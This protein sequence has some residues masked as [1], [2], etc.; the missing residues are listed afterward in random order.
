MKKH[1]LL[2]VSTLLLI[3]N[4]TLA[5]NTTWQQQPFRVQQK[6]MK[7]D[8][9]AVM[10][11]LNTL[12]IP[13][14]NR[15]SIGAIWYYN[16]ENKFYTQTTSGKYPLLFNISLSGGTGINYN[17]ATGVI[18]S[19]GIIS[20]PTL[21]QVTDVGNTT[22]NSVF[23]TDL[24]S[25]I[26]T[27][28]NGLLFRHGDGE[29]FIEEISK[30]SN[31]LNPLT[32]SGATIKL[33]GNAIFPSN[34]TPG[35][36]K[37]PTGVDALGNWNWG[38]GISGSLPITYNSGTGIISI[39]NAQAN[40]VNKGAATFRSD[41]FDDDGQGA[42][43]LDTVN[44]PAYT[45]TQA[46]AR[47]LQATIVPTVGDMATH[48]PATGDS[49]MFVTD[50]LR[51]GL[52][53]W[54]TSSITDNGTKFGNWWRLYDESAGLN[55]CW[56]GAKGDG[57]TDDTG[58]IQAAV[59]AAVV[60][61]KVYF[62]PRPFSSSKFY[63]TTGSVTV[64]TNG[65]KIYGDAEYRS[66][67]STIQATS[68]TFPLFI[69]RAAEVT[70]W[71]IALRGNG[72]FTILDPSG[73]G[74]WGEGA[75]IS[76]IR[77]EG[78]AGANGDL[79]VGHCDF[80]Y[81]DTAIT[82]KARN[83][84]ISSNNLFSQTKHPLVILAAN[85]GQQRGFKIQNNWVHSCGDTTVGRAFVKCTYQ[86]AFQI[87]ITNNQIDG[88][89]NCMLA[90]IAADSS[91]QIT[92]N[93]VSLGRG[94]LI[95]LT[96]VN[97]GVIS[98]NYFL[99]G[100][101]KTRGSG[102][103]LT[104]SL[105]VTITGNNIIQPAN[106]GIS[107]VNGDN[108]VVT[109]NYVKD[110]S[111]QAKE[112]AGN[113][114]GI[115]L[116]AS[117]NSN[118]VYTN[119]LYA[120]AGAT[121]DKMIDYDATS[122]TANHVALNDQYK[123]AAFESL[124]GL[125]LGS[126]PKAVG[127]LFG[128]YDELSKYDFTYDAVND[129]INF[130]RTGVNTP[131]RLL[132][133]GTARMDYLID[134]SLGTARLGVGNSNGYISLTSNPGGANGAFFQYNTAGTASPILQ[135]S[136]PSSAALQ[137]IV[138]AADTFAVS[139]P[140]NTAKATVNGNIVWH[141][142]N[143]GAGSGLDADLLDGLSSASFAKDDGTSTAYIRNTTTVQSANWHISGTAKITRS[144]PLLTFADG[145]N[146]DISIQMTSGR[147]DFSNTNATTSFTG[148]A[149]VVV[150]AGSANSK[151]EV[152]GSTGFSITT[153]AGNITAGAHRTIRVTGAAAVVTLP[154]A[155]SCTG[156]EY[157]IINYNTGG[158]ITI[159]S[160]LS[161]TNTATTTIANGTIVWVQSDGTNWYQIK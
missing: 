45:K 21:Q 113:F 108:C 124:R 79:K 135:F 63:K 132:S 125:E 35:L 109:G 133:D 89:P 140:G 114:D 8:S 138:A 56:F 157:C 48:S 25:N 94:G 91:V 53:Y 52:F 87:W 134:N 43:S 155:S 67:S 28:G 117:S 86:N 70:F 103:L 72:T 19:T 75:T 49:L 83:A 22:T 76:G 50:S 95:S 92:D 148:A 90:D 143:D 37:I 111:W 6:M 29:G 151:F 54:S 149:N 158:N 82:F 93:N 122:L 121:Y 39:A 126:Q 139:N 144:N 97:G 105:N 147:L 9:A 161:P 110:F 96:G 115:S 62:P 60:G 51:G 38:N 69:V 40:G 80:I 7:F 1:I 61:G 142:G 84:D 118:S 107:L 34:G 26:P 12:T 10:P 18:S 99:G 102:I 64:T 14:T 128:R 46:N 42:I 98:G 58:P 17:S 129:A 47:F 112:N 137:K 81:L 27:S 156:R 4:C 3:L 36:N 150:G 73:A 154:T 100:S 120:R 146:S 57:T 130:N 30:P 33:N 74:R 59:N 15:D 141:A 11:T 136:A 23:L 153:A 159:S 41:H 24:S 31:V 68:G 32:I 44:W 2:L 88:Q 131:M 119:Q 123:G 13:F 20:M 116:D 78:D 66:Y 55:V 106:T 16:P 160:F 101:Y 85:T 127:Y 65:V 77:V 5:Q 145:T 71:G 152:A 104:N